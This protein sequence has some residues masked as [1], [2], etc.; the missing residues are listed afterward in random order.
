[1]RN[2]SF[3]QPVDA[4]VNPVMHSWVRMIRRHAVKTLILDVIAGV[5]DQEHV[6]LID[7]SLEYMD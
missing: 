4:K 6:F 1:M 3:Q 5:E 2:V 7:V